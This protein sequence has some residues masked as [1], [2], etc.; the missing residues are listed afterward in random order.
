MPRKIEISHRTIIFT[1]ILLGGLWL[2]YFLRSVIL[3]IFVALLI[4]TILNP[5]VRRLQRLRFPRALAISV[6]YVLLIGLIAL[7]LSLI[8]PPLIE[9]TRNFA[10]SIP[11]YIGNIQTPFFSGAEIAVQ[12]TQSLSLVP[13]QAVKAGVSVFSNIISIVAVFVFAFYLL[14]ERDRTD[15]QLTMFLGDENTKK[16]TRIV[17]S[18]EVKLGGWVRAEFI[19]MT[20]VGVLNY[21]VFLVLGVPFALPLAILAGLF[22]AVPTL[23]PIVGAIPAVI[24]GFGISPATGVGVAALAFLIQQLENYVFVPKIMQK[25]V[26]VSPIITLFALVIGFRLAGV[27]GAILAVPMVIT[28]EVVVKEYFTK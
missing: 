3:Q 9:E 17:D 27:A 5:M 16:L 6:I 24:V 19:L 12:I 13:G 20:I 2:V 23:G 18:L 22:E 11:G 26:G 8:F 10:T 14:M 21:I 4:M 28:L 15:G 7:I 25:S 1:L